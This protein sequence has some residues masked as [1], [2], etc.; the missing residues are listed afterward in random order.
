MRQDPLDE[1]RA[2][3]SRTP[4]RV[5]DTE[6]SIHCANIAHRAFRVTESKS[7]HRL[8]EMRFTD[9]PGGPADLVTCS[10]VP[11]YRGPMPNPGS[12]SLCP[13]CGAIQSAPAPSPDGTFEGACPECGLG[14]SGGTLSAEQ[15]TSALG[16]R[17]RRRLRPN[18]SL[19]DFEQDLTSTLAAPPF[20]L[21]GL[22]ASWTGS[23]WPSGSGSSGRTQ[24]VEL[25]HGDPHH[26]GGPQVRV[27]TKGTPDV[28]TELR[29]TA[30][31]LVQSLWNDGAGHTDAVRA[32]F[33]AEDPT[34]GWEN[35][36]LEVDGSPVRFK[37]LGG[38]NSWVAFAL[39]DKFVVSIHGQN[40]TPDEVRLIRLD[41]L[42][43]Y[44]SADAFPWRDWPER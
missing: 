35:I 20:P 19:R 16:G 9:Q 44:L 22:D 4:D 24:S 38:T 8:E 21:F 17:L 10:S 18:R 23:R 14:F 3:S 27:A 11:S 40:V 25:G 28:S 39:I 42:T 2:L 26:P 5:T 32:P 15:R 34:E 31:E 29:S 37:K 36:G 33:A 7:S 13:R 12:S 6:R 30:Q 41:D 1:L 43:S